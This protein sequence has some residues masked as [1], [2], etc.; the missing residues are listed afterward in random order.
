MTLKIADAQ[1]NP[2]SFFL[3]PLGLITHSAQSTHGQEYFIF[4]EFNCFLR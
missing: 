1:A 2:I 3:P 4:F